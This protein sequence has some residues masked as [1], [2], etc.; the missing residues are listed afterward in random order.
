M[1]ARLRELN[2]LYGMAVSEQEETERLIC[3]V[4]HELE[5]QPHAYHERARLANLLAG[6]LKR[7]RVAKDTQ[8][9][10]KPVRDLFD[11]GGDCIRALERM[12]GEMRVFSR[13]LTDAEIE[14]L[15][16]WY[17]AQPGRVGQEEKQGEGEP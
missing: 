8:R 15:A 14:Q 6:T 12:L 4:E 7:R 9:A 5:L 13:K 3:D 2:A 17:A 10:L 16:N 11:F 1:L